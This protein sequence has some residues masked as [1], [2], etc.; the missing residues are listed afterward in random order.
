MNPARIQIDPLILTGKPFI[1]GTRLS[2]DFIQGL[3]KNGWNVA[4]LVDIYPY[5]TSED[6]QA[7]L[8]YKIPAA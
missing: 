7:A 8:D 3:V 4:T 5:L 6:I 1:A 2:V